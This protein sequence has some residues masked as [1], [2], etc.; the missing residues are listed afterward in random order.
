LFTSRLRLYEREAEV[1]EIRS[2]ERL[3]IS[4]I[5]CSSMYCLQQ[6][7]IILRKISRSHSSEYRMRSIVVW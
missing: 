1:P 7:R 5:I 6:I 3:H 2:F 4:E